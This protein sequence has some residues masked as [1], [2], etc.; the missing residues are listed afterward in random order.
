[1]SCA[2]SGGRSS[3]RYSFSSGWV[4]GKVIA[5]V[6]NDALTHFEGQVEAGERGIFLLEGF[7][8]AQGMQIVVEHVM[9]LPHQ[10]VEFGLPGMA[11]RRVP[12]V[13]HQRQRL[14]QVGVQTQRLRHRAADLRHFQRVRQTI[15]EV[16]GISPGEN[17]RLVLQAAESARVDNAIAIAFVVVAVRVRR[18]RRS[19]GL[20]T[21]PPAWRK[22]RVGS[23]PGGA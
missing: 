2:S 22:V 10:P 19:A 3:N 23:D 17:L 18:L 1:M 4:D 5:R 6:L 8:D 15:A 11:A 9:V 16:I 13:M 20:A 12:H 7:D 14:H 21:L